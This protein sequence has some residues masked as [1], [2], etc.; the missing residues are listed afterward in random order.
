MNMA[1]ERSHAH[2]PLLSIIVPVYNQERYL[3]DILVSILNQT[4]QNFEVIVVDDG[5][6]DGS[7]E[8]IRHFADMHEQFIL[9]SHS[10][11][12][13]LPTARNSGIDRARGDWITFIDPDDYVVDDYLEHLA[14]FAVE[15]PTADIISTDAFSDDNGV[16]RREHFLSGP[17]HFDASASGDTW[18]V[19]LFANL[20]V[21]RS[22]NGVVPRC[23]FAVTWAKLYRRDFL[24]KFGLRDDPFLLRKQDLVLNTKVLYRCREFVHHSYA[25]YHY[26]LDG[27]SSRITNAVH[28]GLYLRALREELRLLREWK[29]LGHPCIRRSWSELVVQST[30]RELRLLMDEERYSGM[31][32]MI[33]HGRRYS[34]DVADILASIDIRSLGKRQQ[35]QYV[36]LR[37]PVLILPLFEFFSRCRRR[38]SNSLS[39][40]SERIL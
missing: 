3:P 24:N 5:S 23:G 38:R 36:M 21:T 20:L 26:R 10:T 16:V 31:I 37:C 32:A 15:A 4:F 13:G 39:R 18:K 17:V 9:L 34:K 27:I 2:R 33:S 8:I 7:A 1:A 12:Q 6:T 35:L 25:G 11:N 28:H 14:D 29:L 22:V 19:P 40:P 30:F